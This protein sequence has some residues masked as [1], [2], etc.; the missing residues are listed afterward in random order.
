[1]GCVSLVAENDLIFKNAYF[2]KVCENGTF[3]LKFIFW[4]LTT[5]IC[6]GQEKNNDKGRIY[7]LLAEHI[8]S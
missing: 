7:F 1:M 5:T 2:Y 3:P 6:S 4:N 8:D